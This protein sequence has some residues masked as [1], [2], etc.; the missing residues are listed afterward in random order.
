M[1]R[2][3]VRGFDPALQL[4]DMR[5]SWG[6]SYRITWDNGSFRATHI[7]SGEAVDAANAADLRKLLRDQH[8]QR[9]ASSNG[10]SIDGDAGSAIAPVTNR[11][12]RGS[13][14]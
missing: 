5:R 12:N 13:V 9:A 3:S 4:A 14:N 7:V 11:R 6:D 2:S 8:A 10:P 1:G